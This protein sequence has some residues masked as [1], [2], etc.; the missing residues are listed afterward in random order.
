M[1]EYLKLLGFSCLLASGQVAFKYAA[2]DIKA[3]LAESQGLWAFVSV[4][5]IG[6]LALYAVATGLWVW[7]LMSTPLSKAYPFALLGAVFVPIASVLL[8]GERLS[9]TYPVGLLLVCVGVYLCVR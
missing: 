4:P 6:A 7:I 1:I 8:F 9:L 5:L 3:R 2:I